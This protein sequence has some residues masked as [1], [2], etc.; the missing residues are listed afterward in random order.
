M[1][2][3]VMPL[4]AGVLLLCPSGVAVLWG[5]GGKTRDLPSR[6]G[7]LSGIAKSAFP[8]LAMPIED[9]PR[10]PGAGYKEALPW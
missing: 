2:F 7:A 8:I 9:R 4:S 1:A 6:D 10:D 5:M 3:C